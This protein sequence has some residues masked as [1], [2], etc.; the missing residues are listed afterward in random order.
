M[1]TIEIVVAW[2]VVSYAITVNGILYSSESLSDTDIKLL[3]L[4]PITVPLYT[5]LAV[6]SVVIWIIGESGS[7]LINMRGKD[8]NE[9]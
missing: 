2:C 5:V 8:E 1:S 7:R 4:A 6:A 3:L 9:S